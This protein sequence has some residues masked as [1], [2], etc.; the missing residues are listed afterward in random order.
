MGE[1][2]QPTGCIILGWAWVIIL[3]FREPKI[4]VMSV[5][6]NPSLV[7]Y[8]SLTHTLSHHLTSICSEYNWLVCSNHDGKTSECPNPRPNPEE[9]VTYFHVGLSLPFFLSQDTHQKVSEIE[10]GSKKMQKGTRKA[11]N[12]DS[13]CTQ[14]SE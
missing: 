4:L 5:P 7:R 1:F 12:W 11:G 3:K 6:T 13:I 2:T 14:F 10:I 8:P 9:R